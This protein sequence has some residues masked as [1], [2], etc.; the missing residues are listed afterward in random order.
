MSDDE[1]VTAA[2]AQP[3]DLSTRAAKTGGEVRLSFGLFYVVLKWGHERRSSARIDEER[4]I[5]PV[6]TATHAPVLAG[7]WAMLF[8]IA[9]FIMKFGIEALVYL[10]SA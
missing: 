10:F 1:T 8:M 5:Y 6:L 7:I 9:Y 3:A 4:R 2:G